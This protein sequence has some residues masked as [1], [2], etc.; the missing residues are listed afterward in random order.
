MAIIFEMSF[1]RFVG[2]AIV[3]ATDEQLADMLRL[4]DELQFKKRKNT[5]IEI[6][7]FSFETNF[8]AQILFEGMVLWLRFR[9]HFDIAI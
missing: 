4:A 8:D 5:L 6:V 3:Q 7:L 9:Y 1:Q 2:G